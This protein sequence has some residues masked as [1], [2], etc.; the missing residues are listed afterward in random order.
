MPTQFL[1][2]K[3]TLW[4]GLLGGPVAWA[5]QLLAVYALASWACTLGP[6]S[7]PL[8][9]FTAACFLAAVSSGVLA[10]AIWR[11]VG[12]LP[13]AKDETVTGRN[14]TLSLLGVMNGTLFSLVIFAQWIAVVALDP[15]PR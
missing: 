8:H 3:G 1:L 7:F 6:D 9:L 10:W 12:G 4:L 2:N 5:F 15:C 14:R 11:T 13:S